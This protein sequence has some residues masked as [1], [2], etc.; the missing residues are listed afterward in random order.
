MKTTYAEIWI[1]DPAG[2]ARLYR[3]GSFFSRLP[4]AFFIQAKGLPA[5]VVYMDVNFTIAVQCH[6]RVFS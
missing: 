4:F 2:N 3:T 1:T 5:F 6:Q